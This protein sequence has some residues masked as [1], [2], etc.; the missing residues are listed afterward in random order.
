[1]PQDVGRFIS[2]DDTV[3]LFSHY[4]AA[5]ESPEAFDEAAFIEALV[6]FITGEVREQA[7]VALDELVEGAVKQGADEPAAAYTQRFLQRARLCADELRGKAL[8]KLYL[9]G[10][11]PDLRIKVR[12]DRD[13]NAWD[14][15]RALEHMTYAEEVKL[16]DALAAGGTKTDPK[17]ALPAPSGPR[18]QRFA[19]YSGKRQRT[20]TGAAAVK[21]AGGSDDGA[22]APSAAAAAA[23]AGAERSGRKRPALP[24]ERSLPVE[25]C[26]LFNLKTSQ[27]QKLTDAQ[28]EVLNRWGLCWRCKAKAA[29]CPCGAP[30]SDA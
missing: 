5:L 21:I 27:D 2:D 26:P 13:G 28:R 30:S 19:N 16:K 10:L 14:N 8:C 1:M 11:K 17:P 23:A 15:L 29:N 12:L 6:H 25:Q 22:D 4:I 9:G 18:W 24:L 7:E 3:E 20:A